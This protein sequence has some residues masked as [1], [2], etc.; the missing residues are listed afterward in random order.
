[1]GIVLDCRGDEVK[2][3]KSSAVGDGYYRGGEKAL[4]WSGDA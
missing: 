4:P 2:R 1:M 3:N